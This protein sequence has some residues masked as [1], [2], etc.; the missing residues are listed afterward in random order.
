MDSALRT[1]LN[2]ELPQD[3]SVPDWIE[4]IPPGPRVQGIDGRTWLNDQPAGI[5]A[6]FRARLRPLVVDWEHATEK[7]APQGEEAP[8]AGWIDQLELR[9]GAIW[10]HVEWTER[11]RNQIARR[12]YRFLSPVFY[13][14]KGTGAI[15]C[16]AS[17]ALTNTPNLHLQALNRELPSFPEDRSMS[18]PAAIR[19]ALGL[20]ETATEEQAVA[21]IATL[22]G[23]L[24]TA[25]NRAQTPDLAKFVPRPDYDAVLARATNAESQ[26]QQMKD[27][28]RDSEIEKVIQ[29][30]LEEH[31][32]TP[33]TVGYY[34]AQCRTEG[35]LQAFQDFLAK[36]A[37]ILGDPSGL[38]NKKPEQG[39]GGTPTI[40]EEDKAVCRQLGVPEAAYLKNLQ[41]LRQQ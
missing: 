36:A 28:Q 41:E 17:A 18:L 23:E 3:G 1:A 35:G 13:Y 38:D 9:D 6:A 24:A 15:H 29:T 5:I 34:K 19:Q 32:I 7:K 26:I 8:A 12:E 40:T 20:P 30:A 27:Q 25:Q 37:P 31:K 10:G 4:L 21:A 33:A 11:A 2:V 14:V 22:R 16:L 39:G